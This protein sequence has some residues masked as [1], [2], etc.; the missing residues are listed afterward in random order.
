MDMEV[1]KPIYYQ[2]IN[3]MPI[4]TEVTPQAS[5]TP[6]AE[7]VPS[8]QGDIILLGDHPRIDMYNIKFDEST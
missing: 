2:D 7:K 6:M 8:E 3:L 1:E 4:V 5:P